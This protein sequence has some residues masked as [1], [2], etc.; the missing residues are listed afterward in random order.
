MARLREP[1]MIGACLVLLSL[2]GFAWLQVVH[3]LTDARPVNLSGPRPSTL[4]WDGRVFASRAQLTQW[5]TA[6]GVDVRGWLRRH[7]RVQ[8]ARV[9]ADSD[10]PASRSKSGGDGGRW[11]P[12]GF[13]VLA[14]LAAAVV[15]R[16]RRDALRVVARSIP[17]SV[18]TLR[19]LWRRHRDAGRRVAI[20]LTPAIVAL[21]LGV[22]V[23]IIFG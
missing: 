1:V 2:A 5:L 6:R 15:A 19:V 13:A 14:V 18:S 20:Y 10:A 11:I 22:V 23:A 8:P 4:V 17:T 21:G 16:R 9:V 7:P 12:Y 3:A